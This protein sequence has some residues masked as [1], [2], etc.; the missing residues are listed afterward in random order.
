M[1]WHWWW[2]L[3][4]PASAGVGMG[5]ALLGVPIVLVAAVCGL[6]S[7]GIVWWS[8]RSD[9]QRWYQQQA[10]EVERALKEDRL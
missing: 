2:L 9:R 7:G 3:I 8:L 1:R 10:D 5:L 4:C 6:F